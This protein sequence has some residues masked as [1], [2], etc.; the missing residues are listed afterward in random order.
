MAKI[1]ALFFDLDGTLVNT[2]ESNFLAYRQSIENI[3]G[4]SH[5]GD[6][7]S[8]IMSGESS[9]EFLPKVVSNISMDDLKRVNVEKKRIY[10]EH[11]DRSVRNDMLVEFIQ[12]MIR[13]DD[14]TVVLVTTAKKDN[15]LKVLERHNLTD[16]FHFMIF[17]E[18]VDNSKPHPEAY[19]LALEKA[20]VSKNEALAFEDSE[21]GLKAAMAAGIQAIHIRS[22]ENE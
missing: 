22:F 19:L 16:M 3:C 7:K 10:A 6:L 5:E 1:K 11:L 13:L 14:I 20:G 4:R 18:D 8:Y 9:N 12:D 2:H 21:K 15:A 17:G